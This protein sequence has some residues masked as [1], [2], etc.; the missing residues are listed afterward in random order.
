MSSTLPDMSW[1][2]NVILTTDLMDEARGEELSRWLCE[3]APT[4]HGAGQGV[5]RL[6][7]TTSW[8]GWKAPE[9]NVFTGVL[10]VADVDAVV[11]HVE[12][13]PWAHPEFLQLLIQDQED[14][15]FRLWMFRAGRLVELTPPQPQVEEEVWPHALEGVRS[16]YLR[17]ALPDDAEFLADMLVE[18]VNWPQ[19]RALPR[20]QILEDPRNA[21]YVAGWKRDCDFGV[22]AV[23]GPAP[24]TWPAA[25]DD[26]GAPVGAAWLRSLPADDPGYGFVDAD[27][28]E[29]TMALYQPWRGRGIGRALIRRLLADAAVRGITRV[30]LSVEPGNGAQR[31]YASE[32]FVVVGTDAGGSFTM[33]RE[34]A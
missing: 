7:R 19:D 14:V 6:T 16:V 2:T 4:R 18:A 9:C 21:H 34:S 23:G 20:R 27:T 26:P 31:L 22:V 28:P 15:F 17:T 25:D 33:L 30:S 3:Q 12:R 1:V 32:G 13:M 24:G 5:G 29:L 11:R 8:G 10:N